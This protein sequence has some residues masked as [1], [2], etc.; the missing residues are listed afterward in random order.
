[1]TVDFA[2]GMTRI[3]S[4]EGTAATI[5]FTRDPGDLPPIYIKFDKLRASNGKYFEQ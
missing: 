1:M 4:E 3:C 2:N 5:T